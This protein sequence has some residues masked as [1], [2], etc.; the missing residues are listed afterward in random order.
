MNIFFAGPLTDLKK[1]D[2]TKAF[3]KKL[4]GIA[5]THGYNYFWAF[6]NGTDPILNPEVTPH[7]VY[8]RDTSQLEKS[9]LM[10]A[11][12]GE[13]SIGTGLEIEYAYNHHIPVYILY[14]K[15]KKISRML[16]GCP[17][18]KGEIAFTDQA[19]AYK[20]IDELLAKL[21]THR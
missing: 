5:Q 7:D 14:E 16:R 4:A 20:K 17:S 2:A 3:Y 9:D 18:V 19:D 13:P 12:V 11:Y 10:I 15:D 8:R 21:K 1:P 6:L